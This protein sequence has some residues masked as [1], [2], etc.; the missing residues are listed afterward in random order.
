M[1]V[2]NIVSHVNF[3]YNTLFEINIL[4]DVTESMESLIKKEIKNKNAMKY[5]L[6]KSV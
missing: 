5:R 1:E 2:W 4:F 6:P 3:I